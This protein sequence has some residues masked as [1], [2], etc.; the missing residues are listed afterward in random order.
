VT[1]VNITDDELKELDTCIKLLPDTFPSN[2]AVL[3]TI[4]KRAI[5]MKGDDRDARIVALAQ[6]Q[7]RDGE[8]EIDEGA[9]VS[10][11]DDNG[12][13]VSAWLWVDFADTEFDKE[14]DDDEGASE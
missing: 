1:L 9:V 10:E 3:S 2:Y 11:G 6:A 4:A 12:A 8:L 14:R 7:A 13:Y 5:E